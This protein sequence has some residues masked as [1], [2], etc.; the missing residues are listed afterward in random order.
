MDEIIGPGSQLPLKSSLVHFSCY[1]SLP[2]FLRC[3]LTCSHSVVSGK[4]EY[5]NLCFYTS[6]LTVK[7]TC[8]HS[9]IT[10]TP[11]KNKQREHWGHLQ[12]KT[13]INLP[14]HHRSSKIKLRESIKPT[15]QARLYFSTRNQQSK[16][17]LWTGRIYFCLSR[18]TR[19]HGNPGSWRF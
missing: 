3:Y 14:T 8:H 17:G 9:F 15:L 2:L 5:Q 10:K 4:R 7:Y 16:R 18:T 1:Y 12:T 6:G 13:K 11:V 19:R